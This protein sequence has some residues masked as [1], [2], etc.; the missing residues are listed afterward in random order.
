M[1]SRP[2]AVGH[3]KTG[4]RTISCTAPCRFS[5]YAPAGSASARKIDAATV[6][7]AD[8]DTAAP[9]AAP[10]AAAAPGAVAAPAAPRRA[11]LLIEED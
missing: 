10:P 6:P 3:T 8:T 1:C 4:T 9:P 7:D 2:A 5:A 11:K